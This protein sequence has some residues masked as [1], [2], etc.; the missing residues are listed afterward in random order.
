MLLYLTA[1]LSLITGLLIG[2]LGLI[3][4]VE[5]VALVAGG[6]GV[7]NERK[8]GYWLAVVVSVIVVL[9]AIL[10]VIF[11]GFAGIIPL[12][13]DIALVA[14]LLHPMSRHYRRIWFR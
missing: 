6:L 9:Y 8:W 13:F 2:G 14:L 1:G 10:G 7:A 12:L 11:G 3:G 4:L 5:V